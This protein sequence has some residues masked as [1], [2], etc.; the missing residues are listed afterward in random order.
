MPNTIKLEKTD[1][2]QSIGDSIEPF[3][4]CQIVT[5]RGLISAA[6]VPGYTTILVERDGGPASVMVMLYH[7]PCDGADLGTGLI[8]QL[9]ASSARQVGASLIDLAN[10]IDGGSAQ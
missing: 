9:S 2:F 3:G 5:V 10:R 4:D 6:E 8:T 1:T 7:P